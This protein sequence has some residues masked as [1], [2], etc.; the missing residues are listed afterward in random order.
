MRIRLRKRGTNQHQV[1]GELLDT[2]ICPECRS[3]CSTAE[4]K[5]ENGFTQRVKIDT[6]HNCGATLTPS[7]EPY[8][9]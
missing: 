4:Y 3:I 8:D 7:K 1:K 5:S 2:A 9:K 6:C